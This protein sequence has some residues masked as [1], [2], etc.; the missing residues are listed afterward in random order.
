MIN[1]TGKASDGPLLLTKHRTPDSIVFGEPVR[2]H[3]NH[4]RYMWT[5]QQTE[6]FRRHIEKNLNIQPTDTF[7]L[8]ELGLDG[9][10]N[11]VT[12]A[13]LDFA[14]DIL[15]EKIKRK[16][17]E[18]FYNN[19]HLRRLRDTSSQT[20]QV[21]PD[22]ESTLQSDK[23]DQSQSQ[24]NRE[25]TQRDTES[26]LQNVHHN[27]YHLNMVPQKI[28]DIEEEIA[29]LRISSQSLRFIYADC[30][31]E[32][33]LAVLLEDH[34]KIVRK[35]CDLVEDSI[36]DVAHDWTRI[37]GAIQGCADNEGKEHS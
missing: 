25:P 8:A 11:I 16:I 30:P 10:D 33:P 13:G 31:K 2:I 14:R 5:V 6:I 12:D 19:P 27:A 29:K 23:Q 28:R 22:T 15:H 1:L 17:R 32:S 7:L 3:T 21:N 9:F 34:K 35:I 26:S 37:H 18:V 4:K 24:T 36:N 20:V